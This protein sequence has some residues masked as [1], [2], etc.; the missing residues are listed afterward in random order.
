[1]AYRLPVVVS[2]RSGR[3]A[4][5]GWRGEEL[6]VRVTAPPDGGR[7]N[8]AVRDLIADAFS[9]PKRAVSIARGATARHKLLLLDGVDEETARRVLGTP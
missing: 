9:L 5:E 4:I 6:H 2:P 1:M 8:E 7:A 3:D